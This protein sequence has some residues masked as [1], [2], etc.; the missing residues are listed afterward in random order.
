MSDKLNPYEALGIMIAAVEGTVSDLKE[1]DAMLAGQY[2]LRIVRNRV[3]SMLNYLRDVQTRVHV[4]N[5]DYRY[6]D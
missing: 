6:H 5:L 2:E 4:N 3:D 1:A